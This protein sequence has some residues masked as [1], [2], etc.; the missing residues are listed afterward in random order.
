[1]KRKNIQQKLF[2][3]SIR[4]NQIKNLLRIIEKTFKKKIYSGNKKKT[5]KDGKKMLFDDFA[6]RIDSIFN[7]TNWIKSECNFIINNSKKINFIKT[8]T[9]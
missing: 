1:M 5:L 4:L 6:V 3:G 7:C 9:E 8:P 2:F